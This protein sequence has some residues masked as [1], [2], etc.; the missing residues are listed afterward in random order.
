MNADAERNSQANDVQD[1]VSEK[2]QMTDK[3]AG[4]TNST[5]SILPSGKVTQFMN[6]LNPYV[7]P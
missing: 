5:L 1:T 6:N 4:S 2:T 7:R 3:V